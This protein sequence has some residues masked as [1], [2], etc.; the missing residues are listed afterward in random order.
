MGKYKQVQ[1]EFTVEQGLDIS[2]IESLRDEMTEWR[3][4]MDGT[5]LENTSK[6]EAVSEAA[7]Q[8]DNVDSITFDDLDSALEEAGIQEEVKALKYTTTQFVPRSKRQSTSRAYRLSNAVAIVTGA[9][10]AIE[11][12]LNEQEDQDKVSDIQTEVDNLRGL[13]E[14]MDS[15][16]FPGMFG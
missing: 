8:L 16:E 6:Y 14:E 2:D 5:G 1:E 7:D 9:L 3:D 4:N 11:T 15:V 12:Y 10:D 13:I